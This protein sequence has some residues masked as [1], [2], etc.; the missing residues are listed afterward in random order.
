MMG[1]RSGAV[2]PGIL[3]YLMRQGMSAKEIDRL[4]NK[5]SGLLGISGVSHDLREIGEAIAQGN[6]RAKLAQDMYLHRLK[7]C[8]GSMLMSLGGV[9][10]VVFTAGVGEHAAGI[11]AAACEGMAFLGVELDLEENAMAPVD[12]DIAMAESEVRVL[13][14]HTQEDW[15]IA[16]E[17]WKL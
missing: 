16:Q 9:D 11:R 2:D 5:E 7:A 12:R 4:L 3:I 14:M 17:C 10:A 15:A 1:T 8:F 13:V 6:E